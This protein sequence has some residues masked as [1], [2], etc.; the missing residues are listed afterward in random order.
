M[1]N[2]VIANAQPVSAFSSI[3]LLGDPDV[4]R[5]VLLTSLWVILLGLLAAEIRFIRQ[6]RREDEQRNRQPH[7]ELGKK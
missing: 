2:P 5:G 6:I 1:I 7:E 3:V 4:V